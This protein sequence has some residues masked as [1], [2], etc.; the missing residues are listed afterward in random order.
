MV[1]VR[2]LRL[3]TVFFHWKTPRLRKPVDQVCDPPT[4]LVRYDKVVRFVTKANIE[5]PFSK[6]IHASKDGGYGGLSNL[7]ARALPE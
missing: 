2:L 3:S 4:Q 5:M 1:L 7:K 6:E